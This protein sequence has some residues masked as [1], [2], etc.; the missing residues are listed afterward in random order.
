M[1]APTSA[2]ISAALLYSNYWWGGLTITY[3]VP[4]TGSAWPGYGPSDEP[5]NASYATLTGQQAARFAQAA[6]AWDDVAA[7]RIVPVSDGAT[8][9]QIRVAFTDVD[10]FQ[11]ANVWGY[12][13]SPPYRGGIAQAPAGDIWIDSGRTSSSFGDNSYDYMATIHELGHALGLKHPFEE[14]S[15]LPAAYD[16]HR[17]TV[18]SYTE[19]ADDLY[20]TVEATGSG[21]RVTPQAIYPTTPM[22]FDVLAMQARYG[23]DAGAAQGDTVY[24]F[25]AAPFMKTIYDAAG[26]DTIDLSGHAR[27]SIIDLTPGAYSSIDYWS[28]ADQAAYWTRA[29]PWAASFIGQQFN[30]ASTYTWSNNLG[31]AYG[32]VIENVAAGSG[33]DTITG[34]SAANNISGGAG[35]DSIDG[36]VGADYLRGDDGDD[37][38]VGGAGFDDMNGNVGNDTLS[39]GADGDWVVGGKDNDRLFGEDG[40]DIVYGNLGNDTCDGGTGDDIVRGGQGEDVLYGGDGAD[41]LS[42]DRGNDTITGGQGA[43]VF[44]AFSGC[45]LD[46]VLDFQSAQGDRIQ[47]DA[48]TAYNVMQSGADT[49]VDLGGGDQVVLVG[50]TAA[51]LPSGWIFVV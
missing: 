44:H 15:T 18:M 43:D 27:S 20:R 25:G 47:L 30:Q 13:E 21:I 6:A 34:N 46:R 40:G 5:A 29:Y 14:G 23:A 16:N 31:I 7:F 36:G 28:A 10:A 48:G 38:M 8:S 9:G 42:G 1:A 24:S 19:Y 51:A 22:V 26:T 39:G 41:W 2:D 37:A 17:Y 4:T 50:V 12:A 11:G 33:A 3:S 45:G 35:A 32:A 49:I